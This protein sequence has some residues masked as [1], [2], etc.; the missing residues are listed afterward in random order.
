MLKGKAEG[1]EILVV[2]CIYKNELESDLENFSVCDC[3]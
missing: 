3:V 2:L 1:E